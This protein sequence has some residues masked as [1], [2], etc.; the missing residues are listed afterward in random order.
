MR[1]IKRPKKETEIR[2]SVDP[3]TSRDKIVKE[4]VAKAQCCVD[5]L[6]GCK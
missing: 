4:M 2:S 1:V 3:K 5:H 6:C